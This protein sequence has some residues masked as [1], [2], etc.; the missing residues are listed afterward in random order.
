MLPCAVEVEARACLLR[1][2]AVAHETPLCV[3]SSGG[4]AL[5][6]PLEYIQLNK[7]NSSEPTPC[8]YCGLRF[9]RKPH[10]HH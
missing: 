1:T 9:V 6:H 5:G 7:I 2:N 10:H 8:K 3:S 4:G